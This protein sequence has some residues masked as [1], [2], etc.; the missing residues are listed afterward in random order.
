MTE[1]AA[2]DAQHNEVFGHPRGLM[3]LFF[4]ELWERFS[5]YGM[6]AFLILYMTD[7]ARG[8]LGL[9]TEISGAIY[10]LYTFGVYALALP[11]GWIADRVIGQ[12]FAVLIG[13]VI[14][15]LGHFTLAAPILIPGSEHWSFYL[16]LAFLVIGT[17]LLK[18]NVSALVG[19]LYVGDTPERRDA[20]FSIYYMGINIG[21]FLGPLVC[22]F[23]AEKVSWHLGFSLAGIG[24]VFGLI[25]YVAGTPALRG[26]GELNDEARARVAEGRRQLAYGLFGT[27]VV[28]GAIYGLVATGTIAMTVIGFAQATGIIVVVVA[29]L[30]FGSVMS[31]A[32]RDK[33]ERH[34]VF[35][36]FLLFI[37]AAMFW[38]GFEQ[39]GSS[40]NIYARDLTDRVIF[41]WEVP[42]GWLQ[43]VNPIFIILLAP[44][45]GLLW[46]RLGARNPSIPVKFGMG[47]A[48]LG[49]GFL[50]LAW[51]S[52][53][54]P[55]GAESNP[56]VGVGMTW[57]VVTYF[58]HTVGELA[59]SPVGLSS[60]TK[61]SPHRLVGQMMGTWFMGAALGNLVAGLIASRIESLPPQELF[62][63]VAGIA[64]GAGF[65]FV[66]FSPLINRMTHGVK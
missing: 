43:S 13:G 48:L 21:A 28:C 10:G 64:V 61:L 9:E 23:F 46:V 27:L 29:A 32:C 57:L 40:M 26:A 34:R 12:R 2:A 4:T 19:D 63:V 22:S 31:F 45:M 65:L 24:M 15:A 7:A 14:I 56:A 25:Q 16:G 37:G 6:R 18:P 55:E 50:V 58:F 42:T 41:G 49:V 20:G 60:V 38:S 36:I 59:L 62:M 53:Y 39:A 66:L 1:T 5:Y 3:T 8:G 54:V 17:G 52:F 51:G 44:V 47:L 33:V 11:G 35:V 30:Y